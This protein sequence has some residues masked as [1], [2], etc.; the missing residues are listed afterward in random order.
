MKSVVNAMVVFLCMFVVFGVVPVSAQQSP[1]ELAKESEQAC[2][3]SAS[4][5]ATPQMVMEKVDKAVALLEREG[6]A[7]FPKFQGKN[8]EFIFAGTYMYIQTEDGV[9]LMHPLL[10]KIVG[11]NVMAAKDVNGKLFNTIITETA[12]TKGV[13]WVDYMLPKPGENTPVLKV[14]YVKIAKVEGENLLV[15]CGIF[16]VSP[17]E[18][19]KL[20]GK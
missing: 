14:S 9:L 19:Q 10:Y 3:A 18:A 13:G 2:I 6:K 1:E 20:T 16:G 15:M 4:V 5:K 17:E 11:K 12:K 8:S 7:A